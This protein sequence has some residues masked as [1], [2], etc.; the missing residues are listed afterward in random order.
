MRR[1]VGK[2]VN[3]LQAITV[4]QL[5][6][7]EDNIEMTVLGTLGGF[8]QG[9]GGGDEMTCLSQ[10]TAEHLTE[11]GVVVNNQDACLI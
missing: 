8:L 6:I 10:M 7:K 11:H 4:G 2:R 5:N 3:R 9:C 1:G